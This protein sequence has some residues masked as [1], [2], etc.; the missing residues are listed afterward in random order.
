VST[1]FGVAEVAHRLT[2]P[3]DGNGVAMFA[4][5]VDRVG[6]AGILSEADNRPAPEPVEAPGSRALIGV[7]TAARDERNR[8]ALEAF[9]TWLADEREAAAA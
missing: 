2:E 9:Q 4:E 5:D 6:F 1:T 3:A 7:S 8:L